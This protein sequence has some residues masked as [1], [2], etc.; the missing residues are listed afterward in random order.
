MLEGEKN[1]IN[2]AKSGEAKAFGLLYDHYI[3]QI[4]RFIYLK[5]TNREEA[6]DL[7]H[8]VF[9][10]AWQNINNYEERG[11]QFSSWL[12]QISRN[13]VIDF[14]RQKKQYLDLEAVDPELLVDQSK[15]QAH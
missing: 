14:Y 10:K 2:R 13:Q 5:V 1:L 9:M 6:E 12:Y 4:Y 7:T 15:D 8:Q 3:P 11:F